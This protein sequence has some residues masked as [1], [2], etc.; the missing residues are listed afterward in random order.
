M[1]SRSWA[2]L[3]ALLVLVPTAAAFHQ[4]D[5][6][7]N[8]PNDRGGQHHQ[9]G[10]VPT[11]GSHTI[12]AGEFGNWSDGTYKF[13]GKVTIESGG[14]ALVSNASALFASGSNGFH[15]LAGGTLR[16]L[17]STL[18]P[19]SLSSSYRVVA[20]PGSHLRLDGAHLKGG[21]GASIATELAIVTGNTFE[22]I[23]LAVHLLHTS[24]TLSGNTFLANGVGV[25]QTGGFPVLRGNTFEGGTYCIRDWYSDPT[26]DGNRLVGCSYGIWHERSESII[27]N[28]EI[29]DKA[30]PPG[31][32]IS[33]VDT[34]SPIIGGNDISNWGTG[35]LIRNARGFVRD[36]TIHGNVFDGVRS[37]AT[38]PR[39]TS[40]ATRSAATAATAS[41]SSA[42][43]RSPSRAT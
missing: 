17:D 20:D 32:G 37:R 42:P 12:R 19:E 34:M 22:A 5:K 8:N 16:I 25:N 24:I 10:S 28:N 40:R 35:I 2:L 43:H 14:L 26:I 1:R 7:K 29:V 38:R 9:G 31:T 41:A 13:T 27:T 15:V 4:P 30:D 36:N 21:Q 23:P 33:V 39:W 6:P 3:I 18:Q 11:V